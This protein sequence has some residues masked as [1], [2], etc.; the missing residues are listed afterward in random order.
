M[1]RTAKKKASAKV[2]KAEKAVAP[3]VEELQAP[4]VD[5]TTLTISDLQTIAQVIDAATRRGAFGA[6]EVS[7]VG[8]IYTKLTTF[9]NAVNAAAQQRDAGEGSE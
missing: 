4:A 3:T 1:A 8:A 5:D 6:A 7:E 2:D 9:L